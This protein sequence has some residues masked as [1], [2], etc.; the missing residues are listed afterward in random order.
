MKLPKGW[1]KHEL[2]DLGKWVGGGTPLRSR[3]EFWENG[4]IPWV[5]PKDM[6]EDVINSSEEWITEVGAKGSATNLIPPRSILVVTRSGILRRVFPV[7][8]T[9]REVAINQDIKALQPSDQVHVRR[10][11]KLTPDDN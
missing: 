2:G 10:Q 3:T 11:L 7:A 5:S 1:T 6:K 4:T 9:G 8:I